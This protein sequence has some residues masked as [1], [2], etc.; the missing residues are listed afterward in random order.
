MKR[1]LDKQFLYKFF[2]AKVY[3]QKKQKNN[4]FDLGKYCCLNCGFNN[5]LRLG[6]L[7]DLE[8]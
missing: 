2:L 6:N 4:N 1:A 7:N 3:L 5:K 8:K